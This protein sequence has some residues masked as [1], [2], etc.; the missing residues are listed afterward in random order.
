MIALN[1]DRR[2]AH[3]LY[4]HLWRSSGLRQIGCRTG[5]LRAAQSIHAVST[6]L[7]L[8]LAVIDAQQ[9]QLP[10]SRGHRPRSH[11]PPRRRAR[12]RRACR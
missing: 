10:R 5:R 6:S 2:Q 3:P 12:S 4:P 8:A 1:T 11:R 7:V 9:A